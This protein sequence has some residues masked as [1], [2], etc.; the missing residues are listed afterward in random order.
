V[1]LGRGI[2][3]LNIPGINVPIRVRNM[4]GG[5]ICTVGKKGLKIGTIILMLVRLC[6][7]DTV[8]H[9]CTLNKQSV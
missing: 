4:S 8:N 7:R 9:D 2:A 5:S 6:D 3:R 1:R